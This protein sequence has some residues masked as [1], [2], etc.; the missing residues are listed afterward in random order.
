MTGSL[1]WR[2]K[3]ASR[4]A[5]LSSVAEKTEIDRLMARY[6]QLH[7]RHQPSR[8]AAEMARLAEQLGQR[9]EA[10]AFLTLAVDSDPDRDDLRR[11]LARLNQRTDTIEGSGRTLA[12]L[13]APELRDNRR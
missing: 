6:Q 12:D 13:L 4:T 10:K 1:S 2:S 11:D 5:P 7:A 8:D 3:K 9:F